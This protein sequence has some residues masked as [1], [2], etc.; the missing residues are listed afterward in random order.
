M[1]GGGG[2]GVLCLGMAAWERILPVG[3]IPRA[4]IRSY[5]R[6]L[7]EVVGGPAARAAMAVA[8]LG[9]TARF[10]GCVGDDA[11][12]QRIAAGLAEAG[13]ETALLRHLPGARSAMEVVAVDPA[14]EQLV[15]SY[16]GEGLRDAPP[17]DLAW[18][19]GF[20]GM[21]A[22]LVDMEWPAGA[23]VALAQARARGV[24]GLLDAELNPEAEG[25]LGAAEHVVFSAPA[26]ALLTE[27]EDAATALAKVVARRGYHGSVG[28]TLAERGYC[29]LD[30]TGMHHVPAAA[31]V[32][33]ATPR[34]GGAGA[35]FRGAFA[36][37]LA[38][39]AELPGAVRFAN[40]AAALHCTGAGLPDRAAVEQLLR[41]G[42]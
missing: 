14:G 8:R 27:E 1:A 19:S 2:G 39:G 28:V 20:A 23:A 41:G 31:A 21:G 40:A 4:P 34:C 6:G 37:A 17:A 29:W 9:G 13:V 12:G 33:P 42:A 7:S 24:P 22:V 15:L 25:L 30:G 3:A 16:P 26:L 32:P 36:L 38:E 35:V 5:A 18:D 11:E 10:V